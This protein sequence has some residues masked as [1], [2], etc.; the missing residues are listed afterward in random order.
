MSTIVNGMLHGIRIYTSD[1][2]WREILGALGAT[3]LDAPDIGGVDFDALEIP[4]HAHPIQI[5]AAILT[6]LDTR[7]VIKRVF[8]ADVALPVMQARIVAMLSKTGGLTGAEIKDA[9]GYSPGVTT[10]AVDTAIYQLRRAYG[11]EFI[12]NDN[13]VYKLGKI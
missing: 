5:K 3:I 11:H 13:G 10:H 12:R 9:L 7:D 1:T 4:A 2:L 6:A 8:G